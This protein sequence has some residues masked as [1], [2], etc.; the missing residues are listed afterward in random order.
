MLRVN[1]IRPIIV[2]T[3][4]TNE[5][6]NNIDKD[7]MCGFQELIAPIADCCELLDFNNEN[8]VFENDDFMD[9]DHL[10]ISGARK[11]SIILTERFG[12]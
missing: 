7:L 1:N 3:K 8:Y 5:Y 11:T 2:V 9:T 4:F 10:S 6:L 12:K